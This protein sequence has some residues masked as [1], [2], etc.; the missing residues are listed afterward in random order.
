[1]REGGK[2]GK[3]GIEVIMEEKGWGGKKKGW[4]GKRKGGWLGEDGGRW[5]LGYNTKGKEKKKGG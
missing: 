5:F 4:G 1:M 3:G 2:R